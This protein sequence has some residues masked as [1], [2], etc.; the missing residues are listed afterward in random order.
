MKIWKSLLILLLLA[1]VAWGAYE[2][3]QRYAHSRSINSLELIS[4]EA[5]F[6][7]ETNQADQTWQ[8]VLQQP[9][10]L[11][12]SQF[13][14]FHALQQQW[15]ALDSLAG[16]TGFVTKNLRNKHVTISYHA[17]GTDDFSLLYTINFGSASPLEFLESL[18]PKVPK[19]SR[20][21]SRT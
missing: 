17:E 16:E 19:T 13:P 6:V 10:W 1:L 3:Y 7:F 12:L 11:N 18:K 9:L 8:E 20:L 14:A 15:T 4:S 5:I 21:Q 2:V